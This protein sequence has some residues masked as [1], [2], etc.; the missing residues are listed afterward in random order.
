VYVCG[1]KE[2]VNDVRQRLKALG[3]DRKSV[4]YE[5]YD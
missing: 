3:F 5:K 2:M 1:F 4:V